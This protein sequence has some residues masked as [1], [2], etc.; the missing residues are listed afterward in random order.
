MHW[1]GVCFALPPLL[2]QVSP[3]RVNVNVNVIVNVNVNVSGRECM[4]VM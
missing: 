2:A 1:S 4:C 3:R